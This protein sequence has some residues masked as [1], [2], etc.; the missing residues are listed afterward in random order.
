M[1]AARWVLL[2]SRVPRE[3]S[4]LRLST[5]RRLRRLGAVLLHDAVWALPADERTR[6]S[7]EW[8]AD[9]IVEQ[10]GT[11]YL[12]EAES[13]A[14]AQDRELIERFRNEADDRY[15]AIAAA[16]G[17]ALRAATRLSLR[18]NSQLTQPLRRLRVLDRA[19]RLERRRDWF[20]APGWSEAEAAVATFIRQLEALRERP[21]KG[22][23]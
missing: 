1:T 15:R 19:M 4:R 16:A 11:A 3:P 9:E 10:G 2:S 13:L 5:W 17:D 14:P 18:G 7:F 22:A 21:L 12:W 6:E 20:R 8:L 23:G